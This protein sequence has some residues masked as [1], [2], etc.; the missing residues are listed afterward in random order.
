MV[1]AGDALCW[2]WVVVPWLKEALT[3][4]GEAVTLAGEAYVSGTGEAIACV[5]VDQ[6]GGVRA[7]KAVTGM[8]RRGC[9]WVLLWCSNEHSKT[10]RQ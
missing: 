7:G 2:A 9:I 6:G 10:S 4:A 5:H 1:W 8:G 3:W